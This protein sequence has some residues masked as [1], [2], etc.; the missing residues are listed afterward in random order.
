LNINIHPPNRSM[1]L[2]TT[3]WIVI[4]YMLGCLGGIILG[5]LMWGDK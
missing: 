2:G 4:S 1:E 3:E 5:W